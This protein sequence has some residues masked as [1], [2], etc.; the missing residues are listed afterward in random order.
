LQTVSLLFSIT[1]M[2][3]ENE[4]PRHHLSARFYEKH[5]AEQKADADAKPARPKRDRMASDRDGEATYIQAIGM[6]DGGSQK[7]QARNG[8]KRLHGNFPFA[9]MDAI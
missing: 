5:D 7:Q 2:E 6:K 4:N 3:L 9:L 8:S 1:L